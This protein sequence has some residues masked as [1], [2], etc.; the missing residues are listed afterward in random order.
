MTEVDERVQQLEAL[1]AVHMHKINIL[2]SRV[3]LLEMGMKALGAQ[4]KKEGP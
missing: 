4:I 2:T 1:A 3:V